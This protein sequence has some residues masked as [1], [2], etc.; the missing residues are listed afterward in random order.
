MK[1][2]LC[3]EEVSNLLCYKVCILN[4]L[5]YYIVDPILQVLQI[6]KQPDISHHDPSL[7]VITVNAN[8]TR[9]LLLIGHLHY[10]MRKHPIYNILSLIFMTKCVGCYI[11]YRQMSIE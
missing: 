9:L 4:D 5:I 3:T 11:G 1:C 2:R 8:N 10:S 6:E 7:T